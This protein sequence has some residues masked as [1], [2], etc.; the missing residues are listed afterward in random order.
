MYIAPC[1]R[2]ILWSR[3]VRQLKDE[4]LRIFGEPYVPFNYE[5]FTGSDSKCAAE[6][7]V[8]SLK[9]ALQK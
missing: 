4:Y 5:S 8:D 3:E 9:S 6:V 2:T 7:Y 1:D